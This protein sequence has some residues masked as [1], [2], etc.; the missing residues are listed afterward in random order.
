M[1]QEKRET[2]ARKPYECRGASN[3]SQTARQVSSFSNATAIWNILL[4][5]RARSVVQAA[6]WGACRASRR[7]S[8]SARILAFLS[9]ASST[10]NQSFTVHLPHWLTG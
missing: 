4:A 5:A 6:L 10:A 1:Q 7:S 8:A 3:L 9:R 2:L